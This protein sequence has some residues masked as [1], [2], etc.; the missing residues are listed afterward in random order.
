MVKHENF[1]AC[2][3]SGFCKRNRAYADV[4]VAQ[5][6]SWTS[7]YRIDAQT[8]K[9]KDGVLTAT[10]IKT[11]DD[12]KLVHL[13]LAITFLRSGA[14]RVTVDEAKRRSKEIEL[15]HGSQARKE[16]YNEASKWA[17]VGDLTGADVQIGNR[18]DDGTIIQYGPGM[19]YQA[20]ILHSPFSVDFVRDE[21]VHVRVNGQGLMNMEHWRPKVEKEKKEAKEGETAEQEQEQVQ[22][23]DDAVDEST[24]WEETFGGTTDSKPKGPESVGLDITFPGYEHVFG[25]PEH[26]GPLSLRETR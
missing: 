19:K 8:L 15:R 4:A 24:W 23:P 6:T 21:Q 14:V 16:R 2:N 18:D 25:I 13:P 1:K 17:I 20:V 11:V 7:P 12:S 26:A 3:Q 9:V 22:V 5:G 10:I